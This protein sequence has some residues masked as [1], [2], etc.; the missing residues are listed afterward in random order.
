MQ[1]FVGRDMS[2]FVRVLN[3]ILAYALVVADAIDRFLK[4]LFFGDGTELRFDAL[5]LGFA[6][7]TT[8]GI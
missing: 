7:P 1:L 4:F 8:P 5:T 3:S 2:L 6:W